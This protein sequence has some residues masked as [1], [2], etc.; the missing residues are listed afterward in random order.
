MQQEA[1]VQYYDIKLWFSL[2]WPGQTVR[3]NGHIT[4]QCEVPKLHDWV[5]ITQTWG[6]R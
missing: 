3:E 5:R 4:E 6:T 1:S 2:D